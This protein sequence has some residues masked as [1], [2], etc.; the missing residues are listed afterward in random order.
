MAPGGYLLG[1]V[2]LSAMVVPVAASSRT[3]AMPELSYVTLTGVST[4]LMNRVTAN[5]A[6]AGSETRATSAETRTRLLIVRSSGCH[7]ATMSIRIALL[8]GINLGGNKMVAMSDLRDLA[9]RLGLRNAR[10]IYPS[11]VHLVDEACAIAREK[12]HRAAVAL[13]WLERLSSGLVQS[14]PGAPGLG[15]PRPAAEQVRQ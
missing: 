7:T 2:V 14:G 4:R 10:M 11:G 8:R 3:C 12:V 15:V 1:A 13:E 9:G 5:C 6:T